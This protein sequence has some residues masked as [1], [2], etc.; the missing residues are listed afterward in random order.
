[1][2]Y[3]RR[4]L[5]AEGEEILYV[6]FMGTKLRS[7]LITNAKLY[8]EQLWTESSSFGE[9][10]VNMTANLSIHFSMRALFKYNSLIIYVH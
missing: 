6:A 1:M 9:V 8:Q 7:D 5:I 3:K 4:Y 10:R 2:V